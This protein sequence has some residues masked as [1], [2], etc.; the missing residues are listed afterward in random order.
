MSGKYKVV[1]FDFYGV[2][3]SSFSLTMSKVELDHGLPKN[4]ILGLFMRDSPEKPSSRLV[5]GQITFTE[6]LPLFEKQLTEAS[7]AQGVQLPESF[8][9]NDFFADCI[10]YLRPNQLVLD[11]ISNLQE[12]GYKVCFLGNI[13]LIDGPTGNKF[14]RMKMYLRFTCDYYFESCQVV[15]SMEPYCKLATSL[16]ITEIVA[17]DQPTVLKKLSELTGINFS[18][19]SRPVACNPDSVTH[20]YFTTTT[21]VKIH[22]VEKGNGPAIILC[23]GF[24]ESWYSWRYQ[25]PFLARLGY[26]VI[27]LDQRG[28]GESDQPPNVEDYTMRIINQDV[29]DLMDT[30]NIP[31]AVLIG[32]DWG[33]FVVWDTALHFPDRIK[34]VA[35]LNVG[36]FPPHPQYNFIQL[37]QPDPKQYDYFLYLQDEGVAETEMEKDV[38]RTLRY[39]YSDTTPKNTTGIKLE[40]SNVRKRG[41]LLAGLPEKLPKCP[42]MSDKEFNYY[43]GKFKKHGFQ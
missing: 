38:D 8:H 7:I 29:I 42:F 25:I 26:R 40:T 22:F 2:L 28:Y 17:V 9:I 18:K 3:Y 31:Q 19:L 39:L 11:S 21:G 32:H 6:F 16:G 43:V 20:C 1:M 30:L 37:L 36:Y 34:A 27:A 5:N 14:T 12:A 13:G 23:H 10:G 35:S 41:G 4:F 15:E 24:P 33:S